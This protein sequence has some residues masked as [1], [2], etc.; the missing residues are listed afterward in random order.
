MGFDAAAGVADLTTA[1]AHLRA[2]PET[3]GHACGVLGYC[4][5]GTFAYAL[6]CHADPAVAVS[7]YGSGVPSMLAQG[8]QISCP[9]LFHFGGRDPY[10]PAEEMAKVSAFV[11]DKPDMAL[12]VQDAG[13]AFD[14]TL[15]PMFANPAAQESAW[16]VTRSFLTE[17]LPVARAGE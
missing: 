8:S 3:A 14:N 7:Y 2:L 15:H 12:H 1:L 5:G 16:Q 10:I 9:T 6:A 13:H 17:H 4:F 11:A